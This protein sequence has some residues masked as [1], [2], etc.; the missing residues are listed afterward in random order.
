MQRIL[1]NSK[2]DS[3]NM[4]AQLKTYLYPGIH[5]RTL[6]N[7]W[8]RVL[9]LD[10][11]LPY[12]HM[13]SDQQLPHLFGC[14]T[15]RSV[16][17]FKADLDFFLRFYTPVSLDDVIGHLD[18]A[19]QLP[20]RSVLL[21]FDD[22]FREIHDVVAPILLARGIPAVFFLTTSTVD[23]RELGYLQK[24][25]LLLHALASH[26]SESPKRQVMQVLVRAGIN[27]TN[28]CAGIWKIGYRQRHLLDE[29]ATGLKC[30]FAAYALSAQPYLTSAQTM[31]LMRQGFAFGSHSVDHPIYRDLSL[32]DQLR[33]TQESLRWFLNRFKYA[34]R[35][36]AF[37][38]FDTGVS[39]EFYRKAFADGQLRVTFGTGGMHRHFFPRH[40]NRFTMEHSHRT[41]GQILGREFCLTLLQKPPHVVR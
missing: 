31:D 12:Y 14:S 11:L 30:D 40:L 32:A 29:L 38:F 1:T 24:T 7:I 8:H 33:Q 28:I 35:A 16:R 4:L 2:P 9:E 13:I 20:K 25:S 10:L 21:T 17:Q 19:R 34:C 36:F 37:P 41:A 6:L 22:G 15:S 39:S 27:D 26:E 5:S 23:N 18:G 3:G